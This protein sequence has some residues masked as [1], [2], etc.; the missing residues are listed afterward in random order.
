MS[1]FLIT[2]LAR[3]CMILLILCDFPGLCASV[4]A[5]VNLRGHEGHHKVGPVILTYPFCV[6]QVGSVE[7]VCLL[8]WVHTEASIPE[9]VPQIIQS[10]LSSSFIYWF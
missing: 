10:R 4:T 1:Q 3:V 5:C 6:A 2:S 8:L 9:E 7:L